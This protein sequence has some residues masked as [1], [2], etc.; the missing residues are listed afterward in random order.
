MAICEYLFSLP[1]AML[2]KFRELDEAF[3]NPPS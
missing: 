1:I 3:D 2:L